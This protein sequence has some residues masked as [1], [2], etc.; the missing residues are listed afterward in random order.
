M[1]DK[2]RQ[3]RAD[4]VE[5]F[6]KERLFGQ[7]WQSIDLQKINSSLRNNKVRLGIV[8][9]PQTIVYFFCF[10]WGKGVKRG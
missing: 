8:A 4:R 5:R 9:K 6:M 1:V 7:V 10:W 2:V 3:R